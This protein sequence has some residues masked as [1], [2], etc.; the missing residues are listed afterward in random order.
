MAYFLGGG[1]GASTLPSTI[2]NIQDNYDPVFDEDVSA[3]FY[4]QLLP[5]AY[6]E[7]MEDRETFTYYWEG[8][9]RHVTN[10]YLD[11]WQSGASYSLSSIPIHQQRKWLL[12]SFIQAVDFASDPDLTSVGRQDLLG[13]DESNLRLSGYWGNRYGHDKSTVSLNGS[14][15]EEGSLRWSVSVQF[16]DIEPYGGAQFGYFNSEAKRRIANALVSGVVADGDGDLYPFLGQYS[17]AG[18]LTSVTGSYAMD[19]DVSYR[20]EAEYEAKDGVVSLSVYE[21]EAEKISSTTGQTDTTAVTDIYTSG[22]EDASYDFDDEGVIAGDFLV[23]GTDEYEITAVAG[24]L[25]TIGT[26][27][28]PADVSGITYEIRGKILRVTVTLDLPNLAGDPQ[29]IVDQFGTASVDLRRVW[30]GVSSPNEGYLYGGSLP[31]AARRKTLTGYTDDWEYFDPTV[32]QTV[33]SVPRLQDAVTAPTYYLYEGTDYEIENASFRF[34]EPPSESLWAEYSTYDEG[35]LVNNFGTNVGID[36]TSSKELRSKIRGLYYAYYQGPTPNSIRTGVQILLGLPIAEEAG[37]VEAINEAY[38][39]EFGEITINETGYLYPLEVGTDLEVGDEVAA[40]A[41]L[42][43]GVEIKDYISYPEWWFNFDI[44]EVQK[45]HTFAIFLNIDAFEVDNLEDAA[46]FVKTIKPT[47]KDAFVVVYKEVEDTVDLDDE[48]AFVATL[49]LYDTPCEM[50]PLVV[51]DESIFE[52]DELDWRVDQGIEEWSFTSASMR[53]TGKIYTRDALQTL[54][55]D[56][57]LQYYLTGYITLT[58]SLQS[59]AGS[60]SLWLSEVG[61][62]VQTDMFVLAAEIRE[63]GSDGVTS[64]GSET[65]TTATGFVDVNPGDVIIVD[66]A[67]YQIHEVID[68]NEVVLSR[69]VPDTGSSLRWELLEDGLDTWGEIAQVTSDTSLS[70]NAAFSGTT[71]QFK[72]SL[73]NPAY[74]RAFADAFI[75]QCPEEEVCFVATLSP[76]YQETLLTGSSTLTEFSAGVVGTLS[77]YVVELGDQLDAGAGNLASN[78]PGEPNPITLTVVGENFLTSIPN[79]GAGTPPT[80]LTHIIVGSIARSAAVTEVTDN[81]NLVI[82]WADGWE[83]LSGEDWRVHSN[84]A[85]TDCYVVDPDGIWYQVTAVVNNGSFQI[86]PVAQADNGPADVHRAATVL[87]GTLT[88]ANGSPTVTSSVDLSVATGTGEIQAGDYIQ[89]LSLAGVLEP[90]AQIQSITT[91][92]ITL[93]ANYGGTGGAANKALFRGASGALPLPLTM[94]TGTYRITEWFGSEGAAVTDCLP[95]FTVPND[96]SG[97]VEITD[98]HASGSLVAGSAGGLGGTLSYSALSGWSL[99]GTPPAATHAGATEGD[100]LFLNRL[101][102]DVQPGDVILVQHTD[103]SSSGTTSWGLG[104]G[105]SRTADNSANDIMAWGWTENTASRLRS[106][107]IRGSSTL[108]GLNTLK[109]GFDDFRNVIVTDPDVIVGGGQITDAATAGGIAAASKSNPNQLAQLYPHLYAITRNSSGDAGAGLTGRIW[110][111]RIRPSWDGTAHWREITDAHVSAPAVEDGSGG[112]LSASVAYVPANGWTLSGTPAA[113]LADGVP[114]ASKLDLDQHNLGLADQQVMLV[115]ITD[116]ATT[117]LSSWSFGLTVTDSAAG[118]ADG[119]SAGFTADAVDDF[120]A[121]AS[122][123][124]DAYF[125]S[126]A[127]DL[128]QMNGFFILSDAVT[129]AGMGGFGDV[130]GSS[131]SESSLFTLS[132][133]LGLYIGTRDALQNSGALTA[134]MWVQPLSIDWT[135]P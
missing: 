103:L 123:L 108:Q 84:A 27:S 9:L 77:D 20:L 3:E 30:N 133:S 116:I 128:T 76:G 11:A 25:L 57:R 1:F 23:I 92:T 8:M 106:L 71:G 101:P 88:W 65:F 135:V 58:T 5:S 62:G 44:S 115:R 73:M 10:L 36:G 33:M 16:S 40:F 45:Y 79:G 41:P 107:S 98:A 43:R 74:R 14:T 49:N 118:G 60:S 69:P 26:S 91:T 15:D 122:D 66:E 72:L 47:W 129:G 37:T 102:F 42:S 63:Q 18:V 48:V 6:R 55:A 109:T 100:H 87:S 131:A 7:L 2:T 81:E 132:D 120:Q 90:V 124:T 70:F 112:T 52:G 86:T 94:P 50:P 97:W 119:V 12:Y 28:L 93:T 134:R 114:E 54:Y 127:G 80:A 105:V 4:W 32:S 126:A 22:F 89:E 34:K 68:A 125:G 51:S 53:Q 24:G 64:A 21:L 39:G 110:I 46:V 61:P 38:S 82:A 35:T 113:I 96:D 75:E 78:S 17:S 56:D 95:E 19:A 99:T 67:E 83:G 13:W 31:T 85:A 130:S 117:G 121:V 111:R 29:F 104:C 59:A